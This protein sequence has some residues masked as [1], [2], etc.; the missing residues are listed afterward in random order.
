[1]SFT[2]T[3][4]GVSGGSYDFFRFNEAGQ[5]WDGSAYVDLVEID[6]QDYRIAATEV[7][8]TGWFTASLPSGPGW[9]DMRIRAGT[10]ADSH[11]VAYGYDRESEIQDAVALRFDE[12]G[13][14]IEGIEAGT[15]GLTDEQNTKLNDIHTKTGR[16]SVGTP[17]VVVS[18]VSSGGR[19]NLIRGFDWTAEEGAS[20]TLQE[21]TVAA[22]PSTLAAASSHALH[23]VLNGRS[24]GFTMAGEVLAPLGDGRR[25]IRYVITSADLAG[26]KDGDYTYYQAATFPSGREIAFTRGPLVLERGPE[27]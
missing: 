15:G 8:T 5:V 27:D 18:P 11:L 9:Y 13:E 6:Y 22:W 16:I 1:M 24:E 12:V 17:I 3:G 25:Q 20:V 7:S 26:E 23:A 2:A 19:I 10:W 14:A 4:R 21:K